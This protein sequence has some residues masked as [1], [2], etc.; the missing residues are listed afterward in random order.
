MSN[1]YNAT[2]WGHE[3][4]LNFFENKRLTTSQ[5]YPSEWFFL[6]DKIFNDMT[7]LDIGCAKGGMANV[8]SENLTS[9]QYVG[10]DINE[11][12][13]V[14]AQQRYP[15][16]QFHQ[17]RE[18]DYSALAG[19]QYDV[20]LC[21]GI[22][23]LHENWRNTIKEAWQHTKKTLILDM[24]ETH[25]SSLEDKS[26]SY[27]KMDFDN[28]QQPTTDFVLPYNVINTA[29]SLQIIHDVC[30]DANRVAHYGYTQKLSELAISPFKTVMANV[31]CI[32]R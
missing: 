19:Q 14:A 31:Y 27:F 15:A 13:V 6:K 21:L 4:I 18:D 5:I 7:L 12:M 20:V 22:L 9:F 17:I 29:E 1:D 24:R 26:Q 23:H 25:L 8:L 3:S 32:E 28:A 2:A 16:H 11:Q 30:A 10:V